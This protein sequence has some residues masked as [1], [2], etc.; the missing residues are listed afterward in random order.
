M[1]G[2]A[3]AERVRQRVGERLVDMGSPPVCL[4]TVLVGDDVPS[5]R[6]V[7]SKQKQ[8]AAVSDKFLQRPAIAG[9]ERP[10]VPDGVVPA[11]HLYTVWIP[12]GRRD[13]VLRFMG[14]EGVGTAVNYRAIHQ[15]T[16]LREHLDLRFPLPHAERIGAETISLPLYDKLTEAEIDRV[17]DVLARAIVETR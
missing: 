13:A 9:I 16:W 8:A 12:D 14:A 10:T 4:A 15:L 7:A 6:Y 5:Q 17:C 1:D 2:K 3:L 11:R